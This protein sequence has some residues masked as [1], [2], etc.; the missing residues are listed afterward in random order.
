MATKAFAA[1]TMILALSTG[2][3]R[4][5]SPETPSNV[6]SL[7][8]HVKA[9]LSDGLRRSAIVRELVASIDVAGVVVYLEEGPCAEGVGCTMLVPS[10]GSI[11]LLRVNFVL[12]TPDGA[13]PLLCRRE[14][15]IAQIGHELQHVAEIAADASVSDEESLSDLFRR[16]GH[17]RGHAQAFETD[18][19]QRT[20][21]LIL[22][23]L[24]TTTPR[25]R[26]PASSPARGTYDEP[27]R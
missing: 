1:A 21:Q 8:A 6:R 13:T 11:R 23:E 26:R 20:S 22:E 24:R 9:A 14:R 12:R 7:N 5:H 19:A 27:S 2:H 17:Q 10:P 3:P 15:L 4:A 25:T 18:R 16:I